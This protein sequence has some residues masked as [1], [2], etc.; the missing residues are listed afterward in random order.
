MKLLG[1]LKAIFII[2]LIL[3]WG[4]TGFMYI[5]LAFVDIFWGTVIMGVSAFV[6]TFIYYFVDNEERVEILVASAIGLLLMWGGYYLG[7]GHNPIARAAIHTFVIMISGTIAKLYTGYGSY[8]DD[9]YNN[10]DYDY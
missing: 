5:G 6:W 2:L 3:L 7:E 9:R 4:G 10:R 1:V 8:D